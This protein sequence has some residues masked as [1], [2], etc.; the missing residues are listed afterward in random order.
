[1]DRMRIVEI[2][3]V[4]PPEPL[5]ASECKWLLYYALSSNTFWIYVMGQFGSRC[6]WKDTIESNWDGVIIRTNLQAFKRAS[7]Q[8]AELPSSQLCSREKKHSSASNL[9]HCLLYKCCSSRLLYRFVF[10]QSQHTHC[11][12]LFCS[13]QF[14]CWV[15]NT[16]CPMLNANVEWNHQLFR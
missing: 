16:I 13:V 2:P 3:S 15:E 7:G 4:S 8:F 9:L 14:S 5:C 11:P 10:D 1:M 6:Q 12:H